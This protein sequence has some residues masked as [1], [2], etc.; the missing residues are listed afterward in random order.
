MASPQGTRHNPARENTAQCEIKM[1]APH[2]DWGWTGCCVGDWRNGWIHPTQWQLNCR[3]S[4]LCFRSA[5]PNNKPFQMGLCVCVRECG[6]VFH[7]ED[8]SVATISQFPC[9]LCQFLFQ[10]QTANIASVCVCQSDSGSVSGSSY[11]SLCSD[12]F[13]ISQHQ[14][15]LIAPARGW[16]AKCLWLCHTNENVK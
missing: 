7:K 4:T 13:P 14:L 12:S 3:R 5:N 10:H 6:R 16:L 2:L 1:W 8:G 11:S 15:H 9:L